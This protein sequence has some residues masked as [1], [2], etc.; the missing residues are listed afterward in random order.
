MML[1]DAVLPAP[2]SANGNR[3]QRGRDSESR[4]TPRIVTA[5][6]D[7]AAVANNEL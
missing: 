5:L 6:T 1:V 4:W 7:K 2:T 3:L